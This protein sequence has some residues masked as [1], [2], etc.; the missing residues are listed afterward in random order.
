MWSQV[1]MVIGL[2]LMVSRKDLILARF[3]LFVISEIL[4]TSSG[5]TRRS[6]KISA[7]CLIFLVDDGTW[8]RT[9]EYSWCYLKI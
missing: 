2:S 1:V 9:S 8:A 4:G 3:G 7:G 5:L 6:A